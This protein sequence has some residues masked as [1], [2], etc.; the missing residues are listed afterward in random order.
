MTARKGSQ[1]KPASGTKRPRV[2]KDTLKDLDPKKGTENVQGGTMPYTKG[3][4]CN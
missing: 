3:Q 1:R 4:R 2:E